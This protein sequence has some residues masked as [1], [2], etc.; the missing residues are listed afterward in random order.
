MDT[1]YLKLEQKMQVSSERVVLSDI[2]TLLCADAAIQNRLSAL[3]MVHFTGSKKQ[4]KILTVTD[5]IQRI[6]T[7][8][9]AL[10]VTPIGETDVIVEYDPP[11]HKSRL[12][13][14]SKVALVCLIAFFGAAFTIMTFNTDVSAPK[15]F[16][17][18][19]QSFTGEES[20]GKTVL[21]VTYSVGLGIGIL[22][23]F[24]HFSGHR[25]TTEP[26]PIEVQMEQYE[27]EVNQS[28]IRYQGRKEEQ[29]DGKTASSGRGGS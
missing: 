22:V 26:T 19:Y 18:I 1:L 15:L 9:P 6:Q 20:N 2:A 4:R 28:L 25:L 24:N 29:A 8:A 16:K 13:E 7:I 21:E 10:P 11:K 27:T 17:S 3:P 12:L 23:F 14:W 5:V